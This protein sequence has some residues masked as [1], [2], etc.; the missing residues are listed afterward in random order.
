MN[1]R[2]RREKLNYS[3]RNNEDSVDCEVFSKNKMIV[4]DKRINQDFKGK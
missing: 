2:S 1:S 3:E 4:V